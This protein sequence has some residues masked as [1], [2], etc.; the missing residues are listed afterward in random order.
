M[1]R[2]IQRQWAP[3]PCGDAG[4]RGDISLAFCADPAAGS[5][6][7]GAPDTLGALGSN[8][9]NASGIPLPDSHIVIVSSIASL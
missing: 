3:A 7:L 4:F 1:L 9:S 6:G 5:V 8:H 2:L